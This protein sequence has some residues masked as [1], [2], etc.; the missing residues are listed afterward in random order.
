MRRLVLLQWA[1]GLAAAGLLVGCR[2]GS[3]TPDEAYQKFSA[4]VTARD[5]A[6]LF[7]ALDQP[8]RWAWMTIQK[9]RREAYD[10]VLSNYPE[11][12][13]RERESH[14]FQGGATATSARELFRA[15]IAP[16][17]LPLLVPLV[18]ADAK[19]EVDDASDGHAAAVLASG[20]RVPFARGENGGW[21]F[22]GLAKDAE[23]L[24][25]RA[26]HDLEVVRASAADYE[27]AA[28]RA[29]K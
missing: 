5:G 10:I 24:K 27:R 14:R 7:D 16:G 6:A 3:K 22:S 1:L 9:Y 8:T 4:A 2:H 18:A 19:I 15:E 25:T 13:E 12:P 21:G 17:V 28:T 20:V 23:D 11:G 26:Y 29:T